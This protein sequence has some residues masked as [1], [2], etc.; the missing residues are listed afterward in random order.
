[1]MS[2]GTFNGPGGTHNR[3]QIPNQGGSALGP[4]HMLHFKNQLGVLLPEEQVTLERNTLAGPGR[5]GRADQGAL[6]G[7][8]RR[9]PRRRSQSTSAPAA[10]RP[11]PART[12]ALDSFNCPRHRATSSYRIEVVDRVGNDS[13]APGHGILLSKSKQQRHAARVDDRPEAAGHRDD[14]LLPARRHAGGRS[15]A[16]TRAS[17]TTRRSTPARAPAASTSTSTRSTGCTSTCSRSTG[18]R[19]VSSTT[20]SASGALARAARSRGPSRSGRP[21]SS[22]T[23]PG[24]LATCT[25]PLTNTGTGRHRRVRLGRLPRSPRASSDAGWEVSAAE[26]AGGREGRRDRCGFRYTCSATTRPSR[27]ARARSS[28]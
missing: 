10:T 22:A 5:R 25:F 19:T 16:A 6:V 27:G 24:F 14:R 20:T 23:R 15:S 1:M 8:R 9:R 13:F 28:P 12:R 18:T 11:A 3:W 17:S 26:R 21:Q 2:R 7:A 4:H